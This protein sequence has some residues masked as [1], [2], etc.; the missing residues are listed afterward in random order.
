M[1]LGITM[2]EFFLG[3]FGQVLA[4]EVIVHLLYHL[5]WTRNSILGAVHPNITNNV[6]VMRS[7]DMVRE[8]QLDM[9]DS[10]EISDL[11]LEINPNC[12]FTRLGQ[13]NFCIRVCSPLA[14]Y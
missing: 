2:S 11:L 8:K 7:I 3:G 6:M 14:H 4:K 13:A 5:M 1:R 9:N 12:S 10:A